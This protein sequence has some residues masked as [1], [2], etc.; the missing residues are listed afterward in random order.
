LNDKNVFS[1]N[2]LVQLYGNFSIAKLGDAGATQRHPDV[3]GDV[4]REIAVRIARKNH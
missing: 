2:V 1:A 3:S 4:R